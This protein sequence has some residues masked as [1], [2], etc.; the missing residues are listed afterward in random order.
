MKIDKICELVSAEVLQPIGKSDVDYQYAFAADLMSDTLFIITHD[1]QPVL[2][3]TG[4][5]NVSV[6]RTA[7]ILDISAVMIVRGKT[8][9]EPTIQLARENEIILMRSR[10][11]MFT[12]CGLLFGMGMKGCPWKIR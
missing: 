3:I 9:P 11:I 4:V 6:I 10:L 2:L 5:T 7:S 8:V 1:D 12:T